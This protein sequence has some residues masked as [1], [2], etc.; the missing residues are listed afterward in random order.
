[1]LPHEAE[2]ALPLPQRPPRQERPVRHPSVGVS[3]P[4]SRNVPAL[5]T[6]LR[7]P[8]GEVDVLA[9]QPEAFV[10]AAELVERFAAQ[11]QEGAEHPVDL[12]RLLRRLVEDVMRAL[13]LLWLE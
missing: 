4:S 7:G 13:A 10:E 2:D 8:V 3:N 1:M 6:S 11:E 9:I 5:P 12:R